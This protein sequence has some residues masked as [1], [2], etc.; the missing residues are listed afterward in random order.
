MGMSESSPRKT[1][2]EGVELENV[3]FHHLQVMLMDNKV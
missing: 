1:L 2:G 3:H